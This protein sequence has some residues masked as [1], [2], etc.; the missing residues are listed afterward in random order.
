MSTISVKE[1]KTKMIFR[2][3]DH[4][5]TSQLTQVPLWKGVH[6]VTWAAALQHT[7]VTSRVGELLWGL[8]LLPRKC[9]FHLAGCLPIPTPWQNGTKRLFPSRITHIRCRPG[10][11]SEHSD[12]ADTVSAGGEWLLVPAAWEWTGLQSSCLDRA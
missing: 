11:K 10:P 12:E 3:R 2:C 6:Q 7:D 1:S 9:P 5:Q 8:W 4:N